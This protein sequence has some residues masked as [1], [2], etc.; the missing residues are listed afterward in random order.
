ME[1]QWNDVNRAKPKKLL[2]N[3]A[4]CH[5]VHYKSHGDCPGHEPGCTQ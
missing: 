2:E 1:E 4:Y 3:L 5:F